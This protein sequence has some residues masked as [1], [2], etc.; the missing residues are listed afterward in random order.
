MQGAD[1]NFCILIEQ[2][3][4]FIYVPNKDWDNEIS[5]KVMLS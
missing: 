5:Y 4:G 2:N 3:N 1:L